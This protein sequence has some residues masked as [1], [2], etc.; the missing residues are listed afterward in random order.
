MKQKGKMQKTGQVV[1]PA[2]L[3]WF[4]PEEELNL[5]DEVGLFQ[6]ETD[7]QDFVKE[8]KARSLDYARPMN[9]NLMATGPSAGDAVRHIFNNLSAITGKRYRSPTFQQMNCLL[10]NL[11]YNHQQSSQLWTR[12]SR[13]HEPTIL[14]RFN[15]SSINWKTIAG[16]CDVMDK[17]GHVQ[18]VRVFGKRPKQVPVTRPASVQPTI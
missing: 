16:L 11:F 5:Y 10:A 12:L 7:W 8:R 18:I 2:T 3:G 13:S 4:I 9:L 14:D 17:L 1:S 15:P 6:D